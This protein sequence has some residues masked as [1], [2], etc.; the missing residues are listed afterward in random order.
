MA[1]PREPGRNQPQA[2]QTD[3]LRLLRTDH[4]LLRKL[5]CILNIFG[6]EVLLFHK[7]GIEPFNKIGFIGTDGKEDAHTS[8]LLRS[9]TLQVDRFS[10]HH[11][12]YVPEFYR[13]RRTFP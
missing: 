8:L 5:K 9:E 1:V 12:K 2:H 4:R 6:A 13:R 10:N 3:L 11:Q 7:S